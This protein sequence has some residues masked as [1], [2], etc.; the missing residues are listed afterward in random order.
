MGLLVNWV[1]EN[2]V[3]PTLFA[4]GILIVFGIL[5]LIGGGGDE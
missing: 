2:I 3:L 1:I 4:A 5:M